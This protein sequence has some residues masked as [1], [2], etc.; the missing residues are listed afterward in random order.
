VSKII[1]DDRLYELKQRV[2][3]L[4]DQSAEAEYLDTGDCLDLLNFARKVLRGVAKQQELPLKEG[5]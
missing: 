4:L 5:S 3:Q 1:I 2:N